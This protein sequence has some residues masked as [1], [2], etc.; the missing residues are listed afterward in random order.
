MHKNKRILAAL[1]AC[2]LL[3]VTVCLL[4]VGAYHE[5]CDDYCFVCDGLA[6]YEDIVRLRLACFFV[7]LVASDFFAVA[8]R[9][10]RENILS[11]R[12]FSLFSFRVLLLS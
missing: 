2:G 11:Q 6:H 7:I 12:L 4:F 8:L 1:L 10:I 5:H 3:F 9:E